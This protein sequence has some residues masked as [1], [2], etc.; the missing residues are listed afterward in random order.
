MSATGTAEGLDSTSTRTSSP[1]GTMAFEL[2][3]IGGG[4][5]GL[6]AVRR[7]AKQYGRRVAL[8]EQGRLGGT[9]VNVG[10]VPKKIMYTAASLAEAHEDAVNY[11]FASFPLSLDWDH[12]VRAR[13]AYIARLNGIYERNLIN[14]GVT[15]IRGE[16][17]LKSPTC[18]LVR[19]E[20]GAISEVQAEKII[21]AT[22]S[23]SV[24]PTDVP[25]HELGIDSNG[26]FA[27]KRRPARVGIVGSGYVGVELAGVLSALG[28]SVTLWC[29]RD[30]VLSHHDVMIGE[31]LTSEMR[32]RGI[33]I[34]SMSQVTQVRRA[35]ETGALTVC[36]LQENQ[37]ME[38]HG[39]DCLI[40]AIGRRPNIKDL[41]CESVGLA[42][43]R[44]GHVIVDEYQRTN[45][46]SI[47]AIGDI[48]GRSPLTPVAIAAGRRLVDRLFGGPEM[49]DS[50]LDYTLIPT[51][52][53]SHPS[54][55]G[56]IGLSEAEAR[57]K[58][59]EDELK[60]YTASF[61]NLYYALHEPS[62]KAVTKYKLICAGTKEHIVG[63]H[64]VGRSSDE[65]L[66]G[67]AVAIGMGATKADFDRCV[68]IHPTAAE[69]LVTMK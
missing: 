30:G 2:V 51:V 19:T 27:L 32:R 55:C 67:F 20:G 38:C 56:S 10:C 62:N 63:L 36:F 13:E 49:K 69:E 54:P 68:A 16:A 4:S 40:W 8:I 53:F 7:A 23:H 58:Y 61:T 42:M 11:G 33:T 50:H 26:F 34:N 64:M 21:L 44:A 48:T 14:D 22:G 37:A 39:Y 45:I 66:Q 35:P 3:V 9:C 24:I 60:V 52:I 25:G 6:A 41:G 29:R 43:D 28:S 12:L 31:T 57:K 59:T 65:I 47:L 17:T 46:P 18:V 1:A 15:L 5:G